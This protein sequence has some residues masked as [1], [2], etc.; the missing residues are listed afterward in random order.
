MIHS[1][2]AFSRIQTQGEWGSLVCEL[3]SINHRYLE[4]ST[5]T[6]EALR[7]LE[8]P[9]REL[10]RQQ[11]KRGKIECTLRYQSGAAGTSF[12]INADLAKELCKASET[13]TEMLLNPYH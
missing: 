4:I 3:R 12:S 2:T 10:I 7:T 13:I 5:H 6:S 11:V 1:M 8:T 9:I